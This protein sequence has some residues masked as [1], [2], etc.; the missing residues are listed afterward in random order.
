MEN[1]VTNHV[2]KEKLFTLTD[3]AVIVILVE[4]WMG[5]MLLFH[6]KVKEDISGEDT[7]L[8]LGITLAACFGTYLYVKSL[9][10]RFK[11]PE[12]LIID[13]FGITYYKR[14]FSVRHAVSIAKNF[15]S[16]DKI[17]HLSLYMREQQGRGIIKSSYLQI[18]SFDLF[19]TAT[20]WDDV[21][22]YAKDGTTICL[23][24]IR[25]KDI[26]LINAIKECCV[27]RDVLDEFD[28]LV[29]SYLKDKRSYDIMVGI[30]GAFIVI[31]CVLLVIALV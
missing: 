16:W 10:G 17:T 13:G 30:F 1:N 12:C 8:V 20:C 19:A 27:K 23:D 14:K 28:E 7:M 5:F 2:F 22:E 9:F 11:L 24:N 18:G 29:V 4:L 15:Y 31:L 26:E 6:L 3:V 25:Y 21:E